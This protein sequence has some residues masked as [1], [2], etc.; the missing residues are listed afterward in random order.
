MYEF[1]IISTST[2]HNSNILITMKL[3]EDNIPENDSF[4][5][6]QYIIIYIIIIKDNNNNNET[7]ILCC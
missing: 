2:L 5:S 7:I 3:N 1:C 4:T 6:Q